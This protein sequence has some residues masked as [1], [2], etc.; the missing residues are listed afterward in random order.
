MTPP[1]PGDG[2]GRA[3]TDGSARIAAEA[4]AWAARPGGH[5]YTAACSCSGL[6]S[7]TTRGAA[8]DGWFCTGVSSLPR[9]IAR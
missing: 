8:S 4:T 5:G 7:A 2:R 9:R 1:S 6:L 3:G